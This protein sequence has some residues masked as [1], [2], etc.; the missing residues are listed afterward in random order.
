MPFSVRL[1]PRAEND[2]QHIFNWL[3]DRSPA[4]A[5]YWWVAFDEACLRLAA[6]PAI[7]PRAPEAE[8][9]GRNVRHMLFRTRKG[10]FYRLLYLTEGERITILR[11]RGRGQPELSDDEIV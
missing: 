3:S 7:Y 2:V 4:G 9:T 8:L 10:R 5:R 1:L 6:D 11:V